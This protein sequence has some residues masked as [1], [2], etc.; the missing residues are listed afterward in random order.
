MLVPAAGCALNLPKPTPNAATT[1]TGTPASKTKELAVVTFYVQVPEDTPPDEPVLLRVLDEVT[2]L[3]LNT[4]KHTMDQIDEYRYVLGLPLPVGAVIKYR[5]SRQGQVLAEEHVSDGRPVRYR[6]YHVT[7]PGDVHDVVAR[8][9]DTPFNGATGRLSGKITDRESGRPVPGLLVAAGGAQT[10]TDSQ[11]HFLIEGLLPGTHNLV[12]YAMDGA[13]ETFQQG[14][15]VAAQSNTRADVQVA[16]TEK[17]DITF[18]VDVPEDTPPTVPLRL[19]GNLLQ[20]GNTFAD[21]SGGINSLSARMPTLSPLPGGRYGLIL[22]LPVGADIRYKYTLGDGFWNSERTR[23]GA[24]QVRQFIVPEQPTTFE[25]SVETWHANGSSSITFDVIVPENTPPRENISIQFHP[26]GWT[27]PLQMWHLEGQRWAYILYSPL[28]LIDELGYRYC[29]ADQCGYTDDAR[30]PGVFSSGQI[31]ETS[32]DPLGLPDTIEDWIWLETAL[33][34]VDVTDVKIPPRG[35]GFVAGFETQPR[36]HPSWIPRFPVAFEDMDA[37]NANW[38]VLTPS[39]SYT[40]SNPPVLELVSGQ[41]PLWPEMITMIEQAQNEGLNVALRP[42]PRFPTA[43]EAWWGQV[44]RDFSFWI[45]WFDQYRAFVLHHADLAERGGAETLILGGGWMAPALPGGTLSDG[46]PGN[47]PQD[48]NRRY[49]DI[50]NEARQ[51]FDGKIAWALP[52]SKAITDP[53][54]FLNSVDQVYILWSAPLSEDHQAPSEAL[55]QKA[56]RIIENDIFALR[57][58]WDPAAGDKSI[59]LSLAYPSVEGAS[60]GCLP[61]PLVACQSPESLDYPAP[62]LPLLELDFVEQ[63]KAYDAVLA[64]VNQVDWIDGVVSRGYY[65]PAILHDKSTSVHGKPAA[66]VLRSWFGYFLRE[67]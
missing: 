46:T 49:C 22:S 52:Y 56:L 16:Q 39:W 51:H 21:L 65:P 18:L 25:E 53:P 47:T 43:V 54:D 37:K 55:Q 29:R 60:T 19:A 50:I 34:Q 40:R 61:D 38:V 4:E 30:T 15:Q 59:V 17:V 63:A 41:D 42:V 1:P 13:Y 58:L 10:L 62:D 8:W 32:P 66:G 64:A 26:Y 20:L 45:S 31:I 3:A 2:G 11:G 35:E 33:P 9:N 28:D 57:T 12:A 24:F 67:E 44:P 5:Y 7:T 48:T 23:G 6:M 27:E 14:A 36:Y